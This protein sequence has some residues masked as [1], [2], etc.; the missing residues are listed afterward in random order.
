MKVLVI[1][2]SQV[3]LKAALQ[4]LIGHDITVC[5][6]HDKADELLRQQYDENKVE[7]LKAQYKVAGIENPWSKARVESKLPYWDVVLTDLLMPAGRMA[8][9]GEG[10]QHVGKEMAVGWSL[11]LRA[12]KEGAK[13]V[14]V[15]T[16]TNHHH[17]P[18]SAMLDD[19]SGHVFTIDGAKVLMTNRVSLV[20][21]KGT[22]HACD[23]CGGTGQLARRDGSKYRCYYCENGVDFAEKGKD[24]GKVLDQL[25]NPKKEAE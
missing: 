10:L 19:V 17:H 25:L 3:H 2:D 13:Y 8:Q 7:K 6:T 23:E 20:G 22:E 1:D 16:D 21:I 4:T 12:A 5:S 9:G 11:A 18:A 14:A 15:V 24:W